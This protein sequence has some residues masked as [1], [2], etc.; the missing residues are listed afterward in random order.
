MQYV[1]LFECADSLNPPT[2]NCL[3]TT[4]PF[5]CVLHLNSSSVFNLLSLQNCSAVCPTTNLSP[6]VYG[7]ITDFYVVQTQA[8]NGAPICVP[9]QSQRLCSISGCPSDCKF[10][11]DSGVCEFFNPNS[12]AWQIALE[13]RPLLVDSQSEFRALPNTPSMEA[14]HAV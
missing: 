3:Y 11:T 4:C 1:K 10:S 8:I 7:N 9:Y 5:N 6:V 14:S 13:L 12:P 2:K